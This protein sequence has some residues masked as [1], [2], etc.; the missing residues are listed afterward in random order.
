MKHSQNIPILDNLL[1]A[2][3]LIEG[4][5]PSGILV[6]VV[7]VSISLSLVQMRVVF[8]ASRD[9]TNNIKRCTWNPAILINLGTAS[10]KTERTVSRLHPIHLIRRYR[11]YRLTNPHAQTRR[12]AG[13][14]SPRCALIGAHIH[15]S[16]PVDDLIRSCTR[17]PDKRAPLNGWKISSHQQAKL[18]VSAP[19]AGTCTPRS[20]GA[21]HNRARASRGQSPK[22]CLETWEEMS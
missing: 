21:L 22:D 18:D 13:S 2:S 10:D 8:R 7:I 6:N 19:H 4:V 9:E 16:D 3:I 17:P 14:R 15:C 12:R 5:S 11:R 20:A 1:D